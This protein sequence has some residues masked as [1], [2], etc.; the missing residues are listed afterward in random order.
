ME[1]L[2]GNAVIALAPVEAMK[3]LIESRKDLIVKIGDTYEVSR[4]LALELW[5]LLVQEVVQSGGSIKEEMKVE[6]ASPEMVIVGVSCTIRIGEGEL[7]LCEIGECYAKEKGKGETMART[8]YTRAMKRLL[9][10]IAGEDFINQVILKLFPHKNRE[11]PA[12][13]KQKELIRKLAGEGKITEE[14][15]KTLRDGGTLPQDFHLGQA[16]KDNTLTYSQARAI[17]DRAFGRR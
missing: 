9:E 13:E 3:G 16:L 15:L 5:K 14:T 12:T 8:A 1:K 2:N 6:F 11:T 17:L 4:P 7:T 10:R